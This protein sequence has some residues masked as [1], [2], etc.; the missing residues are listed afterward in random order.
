LARLFARAL[1]INPLSDRL[2]RW[3][4][5]A[6]SALPGDSV[7]SLSRGRRFRVFRRPPR[8]LLNNPDYYIY[9]FGT[10]EPRMTRAVERLVRPGDVCFDVGANIGW[11]TLLLSSLVEP[12]GEVHAFEP[13][14]RAF[15]ALRENVLLSRGQAR[16]EL[17]QVAMGRAT[18]RAEL[19]TPGESLYSSIYRPPADGG[20]IDAVEL[21]T[22]D[23]YCQTK[24]IG[25]VDF[26]KCDAEGAEEDVFR[27]GE[28]L[29][30]D[31]DVPPVIQV[32]V[33]PTTAA[34]SGR[35]ATD[36]L[37]WL[38]DARGY[39]FFDVSLSGRLQRT[40]VLERGGEAFDIFC[41]VPA[42]HAQR[43]EL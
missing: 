16:I 34:F 14:P 5:P 8:Y 6:L 26:V 11:Y 4:L 27:G 13:H 31:A 22:L 24:G 1:P 42:L 7:V 35:A 39:E 3:A 37:E 9:F 12:T 21:V 19:R 25:R 29:I 38:R 23:G 40:T 28:R 15:E 2:L 20:R 32:E 18:G 17:N 10:W 43:L 36:L 30:V 33:N 41:L